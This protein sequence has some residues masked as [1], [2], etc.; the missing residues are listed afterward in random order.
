LN[1]WAS[2]GQI[3]KEE[4]TG[5]L[6]E[7]LGGSVDAMSRAAG[8]GDDITAFFKAVESGSVKSKGV[9]PKFAEEMK[10][11]SREGGA[12]GAVLGKT[13]AE[14]TRFFNVLDEGKV[15][16][17]KGGM[18]SGLSYMFEKF[19]D[20]I[21]TL[22]PLAKALGGIFKGAISILTGAI[23]LALTPLE[24]LTDVISTLWGALG[25]DTFGLGGK[26]WAVIGAGGTLAILAT[27]FKLLQ[28]VIGG[29]NV[30]LIALMRN[31][32][33]FALIPLA[34]EDTYGFLKGKD[35]LLGTGADTLGGKVGFNR[36]G[37]SSFGNQWQRAVRAVNPFSSTE[38]V[39]VTVTV[40]DGEFSKVIS[41][42]VDNRT[43]STNAVNQMETSQ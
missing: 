10:R 11:M 39:N 19:T 12:L 17:F 18:D 16:M 43:L 4:L 41:A 29:A 9:L 36:E 24:I 35:S 23:K 27:K 30:T 42:A 2:K 37:F 22:K 25:A 38:P 33:R 20:S 32:A 15:E 3:Y 26:M 40:K 1:K 7:A 13:R 5:Q 6:G 21:E 8:Y 34:I 14:M 31:M 28:N